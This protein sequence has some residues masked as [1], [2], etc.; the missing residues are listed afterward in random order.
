MHICHNVYKQVPISCCIALD[1]C[2]KCATVS[3]QVSDLQAAQPQ[4]AV[5]AHEHRCLQRK[6]RL[7]RANADQRNLRC[8]VTLALD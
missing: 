4:A 3:N 6:R 8:G 2:G 5:Q 7:A 1:T